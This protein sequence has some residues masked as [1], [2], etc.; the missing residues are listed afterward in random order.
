V[1]KVPGHLVFE[2]AQLHGKKRRVQPFF[3]FYRAIQLFLNA[4]KSY[5]NT[6]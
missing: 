5:L 4:S 3:N 1:A 2:E 6:F